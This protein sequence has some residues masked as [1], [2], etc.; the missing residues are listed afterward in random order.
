MSDKN[1]VTPPPDDQPSPPDDKEPAKVSFSLPQ[2]LGGALAA[3]T[4]A[5]VGSS[6]GTAGTII[7]AALASVVGAFAGTLYTVGLDRTGRRLGS[8]LKRGWE[9]VRGEDPSVDV[10]PGEGLDLVIERHD[11]GTMAPVP[12]GVA[13]AVRGTWRVV[14]LRVGV[15]AVLIFALA[16]G[17]ITIFELT[18]GRSLDGGAGTTVGQVARPRPAP[19]SAAPESSTPPQPSETPS[20]TPTTDPPATLEPD[21]TPTPTP[22]RTS[23]APTAEPS[24]SPSAEPTPAP[25]T[26]TA[27]G[28]QG[29]P[30]T[31]SGEGTG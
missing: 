10:E 16:F 20:D 17:A 24:E 2:M 26:Q 19:S 7:G 14:A 23:E 8:V 28:G 15:A 21:P 11:P 22:T 9:R 13:H 1:R 29:A 31:S 5:Y 25:P 4:V 12:D 6:L 30:G 18:L 27:A 3:A